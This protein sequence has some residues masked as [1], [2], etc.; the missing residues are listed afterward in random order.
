MCTQGVLAVGPPGVRYEVQVQVRRVLF[1]LVIFVVFG[2]LGDSQ[3]S[4]YK[5]G[6]SDLQIKIHLISNVD[7]VNLSLDS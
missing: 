1:E 7:L 3:L 4:I 2:R 5:L 6:D